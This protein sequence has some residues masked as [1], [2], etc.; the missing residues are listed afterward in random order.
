MINL[1]KLFKT[2]KLLDKRIVDEHQLH[3][4]D[5]LP[6]KILALQVE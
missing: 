2:Q 4:Q 3:G 1:E 5:L 6:K